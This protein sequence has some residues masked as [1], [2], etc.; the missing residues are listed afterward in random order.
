MVY[1]NS[2]TICLAGGSSYNVFQ[3]INQQQTC[4]FFHFSPTRFLYTCLAVKQSDWM[5]NVNGSEP[6]LAPGVTINRLSHNIT[7]PAQ[8]SSEIAACSVSPAFP[9]SLKSHRSPPSAHE[10]YSSDCIRTCAAISCVAGY[11][12]DDA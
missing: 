6:S 8:S 9:S 5:A 1:V 12:T 4:L 7:S 10:H 3:F 2:L 11:C